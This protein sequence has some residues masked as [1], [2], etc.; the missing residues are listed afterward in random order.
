[1]QLAHA[2]K[3]LFEPMLRLF[4]PILTCQQP[5][6]TLTTRVHLEFYVLIDWKYLWKPYLR[7]SVY[8]HQGR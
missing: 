2:V 6:S 3:R 7:L 8:T 1:M 4:E 5:S